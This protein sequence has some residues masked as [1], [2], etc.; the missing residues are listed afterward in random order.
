MTPE[1]MTALLTEHIPLCNFMQM[2]VTT[3]QDHHIAACAPF[4]PNCNMHHTGFAGSLYA[5]AVATGWAM[6]YHAMTCAGVKGQLVVK[7]ATIHYRLPVTGDI[8]LSATLEES[9]TLPLR[10][11]PLPNKIRL[12]L[13]VD[14]CAGTRRCAWL[15]ADYT[16]IPA[17]S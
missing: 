2:R 9:V 8:T 4:A 16:I 6:T 5:L 7:D 10:E 15:E 1:A 3:L 17:H 11:H 12:P 13:T 14:I